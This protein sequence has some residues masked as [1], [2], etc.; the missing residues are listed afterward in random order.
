[1]SAT[2]MTKSRCNRWNSLRAVGT[3][4]TLQST[5]R[6]WRGT[7]RIPNRTSK[8]LQQT[9][10]NLAVCTTISF[11]FPNG[12]AS[13]IAE[14]LWIWRRIGFLLD[15]QRS[16][17]AECFVPCWSSLLLLLPASSTTPFPGVAK[18]SISSRSDTPRSMVPFLWTIDHRP[19]PPRQL[20]ATPRNH[21]RAQTP[22]GSIC[23]STSVAQRNP[24]SPPAYRLVILQ[25]E[26]QTGPIVLERG[27]KLPK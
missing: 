13:V 10:T 15:R 4:A 17:A 12:F 23:P 20:D 7:F 11:D 8:L 9:Q 27:S 24:V 14:P 26:H 5:S 6:P 25:T 16:C 19:T 1:M 2:W 3:F 21:G 22:V 18:G